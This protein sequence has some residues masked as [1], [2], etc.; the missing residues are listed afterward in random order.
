[1]VRSPSVVISSPRRWF[2][3][4]RRLAAW[5]VGVLLAAGVVV[6]VADAWR[7]S[8]R[9]PIARFRQPSRLYGRLLELTPGA[10]CRLADLAGQLARQGYEREPGDAASATGPRAA[11]GEG[12]A[13]AG[14]AAIGSRAAAGEAAPRPGT[15]RLRGETLSVGLRR[16]PTPAGWDGGRPLVV[17]VRS[18]RVARLTIAGL[19]VARTAIEPPLLASFYGPAVEERWPVRL[20]ELP[21]HVVQAVLAAEDE[22]FFHHSGL[23]ARGIARAA[24]VDLRSRELRQGGSTITQQLV[25][26]L[27][28][29][30]RRSLLRKTREALLAEVVELRHDKRSILEAYLNSTGWGHSGPANLVGLGAAARAWFGKPP[31]ELDLAQ[32]AALAAMIRAPAQYSPVAHPAALLERRNRVL[33]RLGDLGWVDRGQVSRA[34]A[35]T[36]G[37]LHRPLEPRPCA[38]WFADLAA[39]EARQRFGV[40]DLAGGGYQ[41]FAT[42][43]AGEQQRAEAALEAELAALSGHAAGAGGP[44]EAPAARQEQRERRQL[45][46]ALVSVDPRDGGILAYVGG[47]DRRRSHFDRLAQA[48]RPLGSAFKPVVYAAAF[49]SGV[50]TPATLLEDSPVLVNTGGALWQP[51]NYDRAFRGWVTAAGALEQ[52]LNVPTVRLALAVGLHRIADLA[53]AMGLGGPPAAVPALA[54]GA[55]EASPLAVARMYST[56]ATLG[57]RPTLHGLDTV[58]DR[59]GIV[60]AGEELPPPRRVLPAPTAYLVTSLLQGAL[61]HGTGS[62]VR[63]QG[64]ADPLAGKTGTTS[65]RRDS[66]FAGYSPDR[67]T[68]VWVGYDD[69]AGTRFSGATAA[70]PLWSRFMLSVRPAGGFPAF[71]TPP[72]LIALDAAE[73]GTAVT[74]APLAIP[75]SFRES[76]LEAPE[77]GTAWYEPPADPAAN[78]DRRGV[79]LIRRHGGP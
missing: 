69:D 53:E 54:L 71:A 21:P 55:V 63:R 34:R 56:L 27:Y 23:S 45:E 20:D 9:F 19:P 50:A 35:E 30:R 39:Q 40:E 74:T 25:R 8:Q 72:G 24:W 4:P 75:A 2:P 17:E 16:F 66:W 36:L 68:V 29:S 5:I 22:G 79:I 18:G 58:C 73:P 44:A 10:S 62:A 33:A 32:A 3:G 49:D 14:E 60:L 1:M 42:L 65:D 78:G 67:V 26:T 76:T 31:Q 47:R 11:A 41:L 57:L 70:M 37:A 46:A 38:P 28:L 12:A 13:A 43:D 52:S 51:Q 64:L 77:G 15:Y 48:R 6:A 61:D 59:N 7:V